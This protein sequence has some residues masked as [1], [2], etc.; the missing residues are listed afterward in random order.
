MLVVQYDIEPPPMGCSERVS[1]SLREPPEAA[2]LAT[3]V[4]TATLTATNGVK[5]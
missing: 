3:N 1:N 4:V 2:D 5:T